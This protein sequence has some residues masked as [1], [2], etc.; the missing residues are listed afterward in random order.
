MP[1][2]IEQHACLERRDAKG[3]QAMA[4]KALKA[5]WIA[6]D[7]E[8]W[9]QSVTRLMQDL[10]APADASFDGMID[11][12]LYR[13]KMYIPTRY[14]DAIA[15]LTPGEA[16]TRSEADTALRKPRHSLTEQVFGWVRIADAA[17]A[18]RPNF[19]L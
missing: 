6:S 4:E 10:P 17:S 1:V 11:A 8:P 18:G 16:Y 13:D 2:K 14:P 5:V 12:A 9:G 15:E 7:L 19:A 3:V